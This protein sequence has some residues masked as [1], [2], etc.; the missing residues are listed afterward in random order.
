MYCFRYYHYS[1]IGRHIKIFTTIFSTLEEE[2][3]YMIT[4]LQYKKPESK[5][6]KLDMKKIP[7]DISKTVYMHKHRNLT[8]IA[9]IVFCISTNFSSTILS[10]EAE[11][12]ISCYICQPVKS[13]LS[14]RRIG[15]FLLTSLK[16]KKK[17]SFQ[18]ATFSN[19][20]YILKSQVIKIRRSSQASQHTLLEPKEA[21]TDTTYHIYNVVFSG[22]FWF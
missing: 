4:Y 3:V 22:Q 10:T 2:M 1:D 20:F 6:A 13:Q 21:V 8:E 5:I 15:C 7:V 11:S 16:K 12:S 9:I 19:T 14:Q 17:K 18:N